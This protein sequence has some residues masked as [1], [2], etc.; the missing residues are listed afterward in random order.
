MSDALATIRQ[1]VAP[2]GGLQPIP[3]PTQSYQHPSKPLSQQRLLNMYAAVQP[4]GSRSPFALMPTPG[5]G[6]PFLS[7]GTGPVFEMN[8]DLSG[9]LYVI[10]G[11]HAFR[12]QPLEAMAPQDLGSVG[13]ADAGSTTSPPRMPTIAVG[14][15]AV[16]F[17]VPPRAYVA[18][19]F[20][21]DMHQIGGDFPGASSVAYVDGYFV[22]TAYD[23]TSQ[24]FS[25]KLLDPTAY[26]ALD[27]AYA[28][29]VPNVVRR[30]VTHRGELWFLGE[31]GIEVW[32]DAGAA[33][34]PFRRQ[35]G[36]VLDSKVIT[37]KSVGRGDG[38]VFWVEM[39]GIVMRSRGYKFERVSTEAQEQILATQDV[40]WAGC[41]SQRGHTFY[42]VSTTAA[43]MV[44]DC[45][46]QLWHDRASGADGGS[47]WRIRSFSPYGQLVLFGDT[48]SGN[49]Y[50]S[51]LA[52]AT[53]APG[54]LIL[55]QFTF[56]ELR[57]TGNRSFMS[58]LEL[59]MD[60]QQKAFSLQLR[61][62][63][64]DGET[65]SA[66][67][68]VSPAQLQSQASRVAFTR[69]GSFRQR[70]F[71]VQATG[72]PTFYSAAALDEVGAGG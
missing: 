65:W 59:D 32:Y 35:S 1:L 47:P 49:I 31:D 16:V 17:C 21:L 15:N 20:E 52:T 19:H 69:L 71:Q 33:D 5:L 51:G 60:L 29:G 30:V 3:L 50:A 72:F 46:T 34:F 37:P 10:S 8:Y 23:S 70:V 4:A 27:F 53:E 38:S 24:F 12:V 9:R 44:Y 66:W 39:D 41:Y 63:D 56:P 68:V 40:T 7:L 55:R 2:K 28:D 58:R 64:N 62:T 43:T 61:W 67:R 11:D 6:D 26:D 18:G 54:Q 45:A 25:S 13:Y 22:F 42:V 14:V 48:Q 57:A 36:G